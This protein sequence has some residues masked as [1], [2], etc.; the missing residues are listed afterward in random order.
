MRD[1]AQTGKP[2][3]DEWGYKNGLT[4]RQEAK[5]GGAFQ[6]SRPED[7]TTHPYI[8][9]RAVLASTG[10]DTVFPHDAWGTLYQVDVD[11]DSMSA[12][13][14][15]LYDGDDAGGG[16]VPG[17]DFGIRNPDNINWAD[18]GFI[19]VQEDMAKSIPPWF[20][21][22]SHEEASVWQLEPLK[23]TIQR[24][25][26]MNRSIL[27]PQGVTDS[28]ANV[29]GAWESSGIL[30]VTHLFEHHPGEKLFLVTIQA[31]SVQDGL[32]AKA[33]LFEGGQLV[34]LSKKGY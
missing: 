33:N 23:G 25:A 5:A 7:V 10:R 17:P 4:L 15:I 28:L 11:F 2:G 8:G 19:Y 13:L 21:G 26:R 20:G 27:L 16:Q 24:V 31:H 34:W 12:L 9:T 29:M 3:Y 1:S 18:D 22:Q 32:I 30:D 6:F 14:T